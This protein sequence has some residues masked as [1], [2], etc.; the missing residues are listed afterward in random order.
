MFKYLL[1]LYLSYC[2]SFTVLQSYAWNNTFLRN[3]GIKSSILPSYFFTAC[4]I[5]SFWLCMTTEK[6]VTKIIKSLNSS[7]KE[8]FKFYASKDHNVLGAS[9]CEAKIPVTWMMTNKE[10][11]VRTA[12]WLS[13]LLD[14]TYNECTICLFNSLN[15]YII[16]LL[17]TS[18]IFYLSLCSKWV[19]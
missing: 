6:L 3:L 17:L 2:K 4:N 8:T 5:K 18:M 14:R 15:F 10:W 1:S 9:K 12:N 13:T 11:I 16:V 19:K 7:L